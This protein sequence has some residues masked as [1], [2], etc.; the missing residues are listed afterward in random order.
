MMKNLSSRLAPYNISVND[1]SPAMVGSTGLLPS[2]DSFPG[3]VDTIPLKRLCAPEEVANVVLMY[4]RTGYATVSGV[5]QHSVLDTDIYQGQS[6][7]VSGG[8]R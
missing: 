4:C 7:V 8:L 3:L 6:L 5:L 2:A 1:V